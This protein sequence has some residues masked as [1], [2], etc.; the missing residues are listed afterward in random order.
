LYQGRFASDFIVKKRARGS[1]QPAATIFSG[2][3]EIAEIKKEKDNSFR[4]EGTK[5]D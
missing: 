4:L 5:M 3:E 1:K 2:N